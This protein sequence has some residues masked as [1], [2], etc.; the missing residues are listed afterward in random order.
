MERQATQPLVS[1]LKSLS[2]KLFPDRDLFLRS[3]DRVQYLRISSRAQ[4]LTAGV[5]ACALGWVLYSS[6]AF[7][8]AP[9]EQHAKDR[10]IAASRLAYG[11]LEQELDRY[12][13]QMRQITEN[14]QAN[15]SYLLSLLNGEEAHSARSA[16]RGSE[17]ELAG[18]AEHNRELERRARELRRALAESEQAK[19]AAA[20]ERA[21]LEQRLQEAQDSL[22]AAAVGRRQLEDS[23]RRLESELAQLQ[24]NE[25]AWTSEREQLERAE[26]ELLAVQSEK[27]ALAQ[28]RSQLSSQ[29]ALLETA[30][31][32]AQSYQTTL[33]GNIGR[34]EGSLSAALDRAEQAVKQR[35][36]LEQQVVGLQGL[37]DDMRDQ[38]REIVERVA[39][40]TVASITD[41][42]TLVKDTG[43]DVAE[44]IT[45]AEGPQGGQG[46]PFIPADDLLAT[47]AAY[48]L[49]VSVAMLDLRLDRWDALQRIAQV[50]PLALPVEH[51]EI[52]SSFG[53]R[54][55]PINGRLALHTGIDFSAP[56]G[57][58]L[59]ATGPGVV[60][61][62]GWRGRYGRVVEV[63]HGYGI[64]TR[65]AHLS[66]IS[67]KKGQSVAVGDELG[68]SGSSGRATGPHL[69]Y[70]VLFDEKPYDPIK[71]ITAGKLE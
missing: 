11:A 17:Q 71:F 68:T 28:E 70:E 15:Q 38:Q 33:E 60:S 64:K 8:L 29:V 27:D 5:A 9:Y 23:V 10:E 49:Q 2:D 19:A 34:L 55:D 66:S 31:A 62:T 47:D 65:F 39:G 14:L 22:A 25:A 3:N 59:Y 13:S 42:E 48:E 35:D 45:R 36:Q 37:I 61:F 6:L 24:E 69:H 1:R 53:Y 56:R 20:R 63:D 51:Y 26:A 58:A 41:L 67:V 52:T 16:L 12:K 43:L 57:T 30:L 54:K 44:L 7:F 40:R 50:L 18:I 46:G 4:K 32:E 21:L